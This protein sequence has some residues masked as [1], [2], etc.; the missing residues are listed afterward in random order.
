MSSVSDLLAFIAENEVSHQREDFIGLLSAQTV[1]VLRATK[2]S[3]LHDLLKRSGFDTLKS[4]YHL[5]VDVK[6]LV[7][8]LEKLED[9]RNHR[10]S[11]VRS[12]Q[13]VLK[14]TIKSFAPDMLMS[15]TLEKGFHLDGVFLKPYSVFFDGV[16]LL[17]DISGFTRLSGQYC[18]GGRD[19]ID[20]L[21]QATNGYLGELVKTVYSYGGDVLKFAGDALVCVFQSRRYTESGISLVLADICSNS[22]QCAT[23]LAQICTPHLTIHVAV[24]CGPMCF[25]MLGGHNDVWES[26][27]SGACLGDLSQCLDDAKSKQTVVSQKFV[28]TLG[29]MYR[30]ELKLESL[31][32][33]NFRVISASSINTGVVQKMI[34]KRAE[35][36]L[37]DCEAR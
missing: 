30:R 37:Q 25:A 20:E 11:P 16:C 12:S 34:K 1:A 6:K 23:V 24:S 33:G 19:G 2:D 35:M 10:L 18:S 3:P 26:L 14:N 22:V 31:P 27:V 8:S 9:R 15:F 13:I 36:L 21:Q 7:I 28:E 4:S 17:A 5:D 29:P 32:S